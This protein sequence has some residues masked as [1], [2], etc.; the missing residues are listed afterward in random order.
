MV[1]TWHFCK[2]TENIIF[3]LVYV[4]T[5]YHVCKSRLDVHTQPHPKIVSCIIIVCRILDIVRGIMI[6]FWCY[7]FQWVMKQTNPSNHVIMPVSFL[8]FCYFIFWLS[9]FLK[10]MLFSFSQNIKWEIKVRLEARYCQN[11]KY[12]TTR[13]NNWCNGANNMI[14][15]DNTT[16]VMIN[17][18]NELCDVPQKEKTYILILQY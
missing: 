1:S 5:S 4:S 10:N 7:E 13:N 2:L 12:F 17:F 14:T 8:F 11:Q 18:Y 15:Y 3:T 9:S 6:T 16:S